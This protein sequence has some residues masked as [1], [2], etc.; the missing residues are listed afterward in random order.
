[1]SKETNR[2]T[3]REV[4]PDVT[5]TIWSD[6]EKPNDL[7]PEGI[8][9]NEE[10]YAFI[11]Q[12]STTYLKVAVNLKAYPGHGFKRASKTAGQAKA[13]TPS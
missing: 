3:L 9:F 10:G 13:Y 1:M 7:L 4:F 6:A 8:E 2:D 11:D 12:T 5:T